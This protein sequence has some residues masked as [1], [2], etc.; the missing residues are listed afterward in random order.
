MGF[1]MNPENQRAVHPLNLKWHQ[2]SGP[3]TYAH[4]EKASEVIQDHAGARTSLARRAPTMIDLQTNSGYRPN[5]EIQP[6]IQM[7]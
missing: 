3:G 6:D 4:V 2:V 7:R 1:A 5:L